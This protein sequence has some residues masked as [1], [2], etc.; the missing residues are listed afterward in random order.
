MGLFCQSLLYAIVKGNVVYLT[1]FNFA[2]MISL[3]QLRA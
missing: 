1:T 2:I 3:L